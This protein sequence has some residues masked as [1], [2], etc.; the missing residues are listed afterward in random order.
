MVMEDCVGGATMR[1]ETGHNEVHGSFTPSNDMT[2]GWEQTSVCL[3]GPYHTHWKQE[4]EIRAKERNPC[5][6]GI[7]CERVHHTHQLD[8]CC[9]CL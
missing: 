4:K 8:Q 7:L 3:N 9:P 5:Q 1:D 2:L 6:G